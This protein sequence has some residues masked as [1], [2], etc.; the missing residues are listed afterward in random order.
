MIVVLGFLSGR[1]SRTLTLGSSDFENFVHPW[2]TPPSSRKKFGGRCT[3]IAELKPSTVV[4]MTS[5]TPPDVFALAEYDPLEQAKFKL[6]FLSIVNFG[7]HFISKYMHS[8]N[9][10][11]FPRQI[12]PGSI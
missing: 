12:D 11:I 7:F 9:K 2:R 6:G 1:K 10:F 3:E 8:G 5:R 4:L